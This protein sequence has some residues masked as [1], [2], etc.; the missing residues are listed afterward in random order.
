MMTV[1]DRST[2]AADRL[3]REALHRVRS[4]LRRECL[5]DAW[6]LLQERDDNGNARGALPWTA[7]LKAVVEAGRPTAVRIRIPQ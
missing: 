1:A 6:N 3:T 5:V 2:G 4:V 7:P